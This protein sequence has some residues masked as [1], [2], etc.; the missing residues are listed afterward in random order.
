[1][2]T[3]TEHIDW[4][5]VPLGEMTDREI[6]EQIGVSRDCVRYH[7]N[8]LNIPPVTPGRPSVTD[9]S[10]VDFSRPSREIA[11]EIGVSPQAVRYNRQRIREAKQSAE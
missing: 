5:A 10:A 8:R 1:M 7:R 9:W 11:D 2:S 4:S 3:D 6:A